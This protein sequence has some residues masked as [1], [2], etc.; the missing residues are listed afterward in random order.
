[1]TGMTTSIE[2]RDAATAQYVTATATINAVFDHADNMRGLLAQIRVATEIDD[3]LA[4]SRTIQDLNLQLDDAV[5][6]LLTGANAAAAY[7]S[8]SDIAGDLGT[9]TAILFPRT[10][11]TRDDS[12]GTNPE[13][14]AGDDQ[15]QR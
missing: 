14:P 4:A 12:A 15:E 10:A 11:R 6:A 8:R 7:R 2:R 5:T 9:R 3:V 1:M 13:I